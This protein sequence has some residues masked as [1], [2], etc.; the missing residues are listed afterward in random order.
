MKISGKE[1]LCEVKIFFCWYIHTIDFIWGQPR[2]HP[3]PCQD[4]HCYQDK[5][6]TRPQSAVG[7]Y[8]AYHDLHRNLKY[9]SAAAMAFAKV[10]FTRFYKKVPG[11]DTLNLVQISS[12][13]RKTDPLWKNLVHFFPKKKLIIGTIKD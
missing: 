13:F 4:Q 9:V 1:R 10:F 2:I 6:G 7:K 8:T 3:H 12:G 11:S 5:S